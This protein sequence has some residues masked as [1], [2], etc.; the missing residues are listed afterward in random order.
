MMQGLVSS[1]G[2]YQIALAAK[3]HQKQFYALAESYKFLRYY[4]LRQTDLPAPK[5]NGQNPSEPLSFPSFITPLRHP[6]TNE[7]STLSREGSPTPPA[8]SNPVPGSRKVYEMTAEMEAINPLVD[9]T[10]PDL[11]DL[12]FTDLGMP[13]TPTS[14]SQYLVAQFST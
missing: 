2:T 4:P 6:G 10:S 12:I 1:V 9:V 7:A 11:I 8:V 5:I 14:V 3:Y 13:L